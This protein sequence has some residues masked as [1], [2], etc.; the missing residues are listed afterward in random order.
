MQFRQEMRVTQIRA[1]AVEKRSD[2]GYILK[3]EPT[4][5]VRGLD[6]GYERKREVKDTRKSLAQELER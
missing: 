1:M 4:G 2:L 6:K 5:F 3:V